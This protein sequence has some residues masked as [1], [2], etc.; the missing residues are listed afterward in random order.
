MR[1]ITD[2]ELKEYLDEIISCQAFEFHKTINED[3]TCDCYIPYMMNDALECYLLLD[4]ARMTGECRPAPEPVV[5]AEIEQTE[6][7]TAV[8][9]YQGTD[10]VFTVWYRGSYQ[11]LK[12]FRYDQIGHFWVEGE[13]H[14]RRLVYIIGTIHDKYNYMGESV[15]NPQEM[16]LMPLMEFAPFRYFSPIHDPLDGYYEDS[17]EGLEAMKA[18]AWEAGDRGFLRLLALYEACPLKKPVEKQMIRAMQ[19]AK[20]TGLYRLIFEKVQNASMCY[21]ERTYPE[22]QQ[23]Q[24]EQLRTESAEILQKAGFSGRYPVFRRKNTEVLAMEEHP[25]TILESEQYRFKIQ[26]MVSESA[27]SGRNAGFFRGRGNRSRIA[28]SPEE[29]E[30]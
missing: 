22:A 30:L 5:R 29:L 3:G 11:V 4:G 9:F 26:F 10:N 16:E 8:I 1:K 2:S 15:C 20:R 18:L 12:C 25:F 23:R 14:W 21:P 24:I 19:S 13:E 28:R 17:R 6:E 7:G 27:E